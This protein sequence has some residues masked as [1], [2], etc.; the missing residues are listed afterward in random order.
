M[1]GDVSAGR[2]VTERVVHQVGEHLAERVEVGAHRRRVRRRPRASNSTALRVGPAGQRRPGL[3]RRRVDAP[4]P[5]ASGCQRPDSMRDRSSRSS[6]SRCIRRALLRIV[7]RKRR[8]VSGSGGCRQQGLGVARDRGERGLEL[9]GHVGHEVAAHRLQAPQLGEIVH[10][11]H[12]A[13]GGE[14]PRVEQQRAA[15]QLEL[16]DPAPVRRRARRPRPRAPPSPGTAPARSGSESSRIVAQEPPRRGVRGDDVAPLVRGDHPFHHGFD[17]RRRLGLL[18]AQLVEAI[19]QLA[20]HLAERL[21]QRVDVGHA[22]SAGSGEGSRR[23]WRA[24]RW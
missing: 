17:Q 14:R 2:G 24:P 8:V 18:P 12:G 6:T 20:V 23:R 9:V 16:A 4:P 1:A 13:A 21:D 3:A 22:R 15:V 7:P 19:A 10:H 5:R 11:Q